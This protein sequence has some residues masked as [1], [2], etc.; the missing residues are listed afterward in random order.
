MTL[1]LWK[2]MLRHPVAALDEWWDRTAPSRRLDRNAANLCMLVGLMLPAL[3]IVLVGPTPSSTLMDMSEQLQIAMCTCI[4]IGASIKLHGALS[5][6]RFYFCGTSLRRCYQ[7]GYTG[8][9]IA[10][11][12]LF[13]YGYYLLE[14]TTTWSSAMGT[15]GTT[16]FALG[17]LLQ[18][19][20]YW[21]E[22]RRIETKERQLIRIA[23][24]AKAS[25]QEMD[26]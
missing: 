22:A 18:G 23:K 10:A 5:H 9:P 20:V 3:S 4:F 25:R 15:I 1:Q 12:G 21:L 24:A 2:T 17:V 11:S 13:V 6:S 16:F 26:P 7:I 14:N 8:A 19:F